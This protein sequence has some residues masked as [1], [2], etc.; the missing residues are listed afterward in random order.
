[1]IPSL[2]LLAP[3]TKRAQAR[4]RVLL[5]LHEVILILFIG[6]VLG[7]VLFLGAH[8]LLAKRLREVLLEPIPGTAKIER[9]NTQVRAANNKL[10]ALDRAV[11]KFP[12]WSPVIAELLSRIPPG[13]LLTALTL[14]QPGVLELHGTALGRDDLLQL[15]TALTESAYFSAIDLPLQYLTQLKKN[16][17]ILRAT[18]NPTA[19]TPL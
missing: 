9:L 14:N 17:F 19:L 6:T 10:T 13:I 12:R 5:L 1:M 16:T 8:A 4:M 18:I 7:T 15:K 11:E 3:A 2:N